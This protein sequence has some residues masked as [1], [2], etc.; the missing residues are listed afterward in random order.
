MAYRTKSFHENSSFAGGS[1]AQA[2]PPE[3]GTS[4]LFSKRSLYACSIPNPYLL[5]AI[6]RVSVTYL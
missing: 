1:K 6:S 5:P 2:I 3:T 4:V